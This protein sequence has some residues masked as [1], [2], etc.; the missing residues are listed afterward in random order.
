MGPLEV[1][2][3]RRV[4]KAAELIRTWGGPALMRSTT[5]GWAPLSNHEGGI[6]TLSINVF[7]SGYKPIPNPPG[8][9][10]AAASD[11]AGLDVNADRR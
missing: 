2:T 6:L 3:D 4:A 9:D 10:C 11:L 1:V 5:L 7:N 8:W